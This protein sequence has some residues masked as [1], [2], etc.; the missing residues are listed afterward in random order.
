MC[1][2]LAP[3]GGRGAA[4][5]ESR[6]QEQPGRACSPAACVAQTQSTSSLT[7]AMVRRQGRGELLRRGA[8]SSHER[9]VNVAA[10]LLQLGHG[11]WTKSTSSRSPPPS[12]GL[13]LGFQV[14]ETSHAPRVNSPSSDSSSN[15][16]RER[17]ARCG[18]LPAAA[19]EVADFAQEEAAAPSG[20]PQLH[21]RR[22]ALHPT[23]LRK[24]QLFS[25]TEMPSPFFERCGR[26]GLGCACGRRDPLVSS[27][28][29]VGRCENTA[30]VTLDPSL[31]AWSASPSTKQTLPQPASRSK[32]CSPNYVQAQPPP[33]GLA[34][35]PAG[36]KAQPGWPLMSILS[37]L[38]S[39]TTVLSTERAR[40]GRRWRA[41]ITK[42]WWSIP[43]AIGC[44]LFHGIVNVLRDRTGQ[45]FLEHSSIG[46][47]SGVYT[48][49]HTECEAIWDLA[50]P[51]PPSP[52]P[53]RARA[54][55][56]GESTHKDCTLCT[57]SDHSKHTMP[58]A[59]P[60][61]WQA[62]HAKRH[63][64]VVRVAKMVNQRFDRIEST[65]SA[66][67][68]KIDMLT[69]KIVVSSEIEVR[70][71]STHS[72]L[73]LETRIN[74]IE[75]L[76]YR[77]PV[78]D[79]QHIDMMIDNIV[80]K[81]IERNAELQMEFTPDRLNHSPGCKS[82]RKAPV[83][84]PHRCGH[85]STPGGTQ[86]WR[87]QRAR[88]VAPLRERGRPPG[89]ESARGEALGRASRGA[90]SA[91]RLGAALP[92]VGG[93]PRRAMAS[94]PAPAVV[95]AQQASRQ[96]R[97]LEPLQA[98]G[99]A[100]GGG[101]MAAAAADAVPAL[102]GVDQVAYLL[103]AVPGA[104]LWHQ[105]WNLGRVVS[106]PSDA[107]LVSP[108]HQVQCEVVDGTSPD[109]SAVRWAPAL[110][111]RPPGVV[112][113]Y[114]FASAP[115]AAEV[116]AWLPEAQAEARRCFAR[117]HQG[118]AVPAPVFEAGGAPAPAGAALAAAVVGGARPLVLAGGAGDA[119]PAPVGNRRVAQEWRGYHYGDVIIPPAGFAGAGTP[120]RGVVLL[121]DGSSLFVEWVAIGDESDFAD[122]AVA[123]DCRLLPARLDRAGRPFRT[124]ENLVESCRQ[125]H[126]P[127]FIAPRTTMWC[128]EHLAGEGRSLESHFEH[129]KKLRGLQDS[130]WGMEEYASVISYLKALLQ[131]DQVDASNILSVEMMFR[132]LQTI[133]YC[134]SDKLRE[135]TAGSSAGR[136]T[137]DEQAAFGATARA[138]SRLMVSPALLES[139]KQ[140]LER[141]A[142][143]AKSLLKAREARESLGKRRQGQ[144]KD[145]G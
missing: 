89:A 129:F 6:R 41:T 21:A 73:S 127:D 79:F 119:A 109:I 134:Y 116:A 64:A 16:D 132:R 80:S 35:S 143:L 24:N 7:S 83:R 11:L 9:S 76:L 105:R 31:V 61:V 17:P 85:E 22:N 50:A 139:A 33:T 99:S 102:E 130:Q 138:E 69:K 115:T 112:R 10:E 59:V 18:L 14:S 137:A 40:L 74:R 118:V 111:P 131:H 63:E 78:A 124:L 15:A 140:E 126:L 23:E 91:S 72:E 92:D 67:V 100:E 113:A 104:P 87:G 26:Q 144:G 114:R 86:E 56:G 145:Q 54:R 81:T 34:K 82:Q 29:Q 36:E 55:V 123:P 120:A 60:S 96:P 28:S 103:Y 47:F 128:L 46:R 12:A 70:T 1:P 75:L 141:D 135:R 32:I 97:R 43:V 49:M 37:A 51:A 4:A 30:Q 122:R 71:P 27:T 101:A 42:S 90:G 19:F 136:L 57:D 48:S 117:R 98:S 3:L 133:E 93:S 45:R 121:A 39:D 68:S 107:I 13:A 106:R 108:D 66:T 95:G 2:S 5:A 142:S 25:G 58:M 65:V 44:I 20:Q 8:P 125:E 88:R 53:R 110:A 52:S 94:A 62:Q 84:R 38:H 77:T